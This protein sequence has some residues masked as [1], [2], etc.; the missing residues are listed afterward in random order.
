MTESADPK[1]RRLLLFDEDGYGQF[2][3]TDILPLAHVELVYVHRL[4]QVYQMI[5]EGLFDAVALN[6]ETLN[7][8]EMTPIADLHRL[9]SQLPII[10][11]SD[12]N[13]VDVALE[14]LR[15]GAVDFLVKPFNN[16]A[17]VESALANAFEKKNKALEHLALNKEIMATHG[18]LGESPVLRNMLEIIAQVAPLD[19]SVL[20]TGESGSGKELV[21]RSIHARSK[22][23]QEGFFAINCG[24][25]PDG[26]VESIFFGHKKGSFTGADAHHQGILEKADQ[27]TLFLDE[28]GEMSPK[29]QV[30]LL[31]FLQERE[32][33]RVGGVRSM[34]SDVRIIASTNRNLEEE[35]V[36]KRF[37]EDLFFRLNVVRITA[38]PLRER[39]ADILLLAEHFAR[40]F[41]LRRDQPW[42]SLSPKA[43]E[44]LLRYPW[45]GNVRELKNL[46]NGLTATLPANHQ[47]LSARDLIKFS[48]RFS[49]ASVT[50]KTEQEKLTEMGF[51][52]AQSAFARDYFENLLERHQGNVT[53]AAQAAG[54]H[55]ITLHRNLQ[56]LGLKKPQKRRSEL[57]LPAP[58]RRESAR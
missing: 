24:A 35:V 47:P 28:I 56:K 1:K 7:Y 2:F 33:V 57:N 42:S 38:P 34:T 5:Q 10:V 17:R 25:L 45:P 19:I 39:G 21:A 32:F 53:R 49:Q 52:E 26:L 51:E 6:I 58:S 31:R 3:F 23:A 48:D 43:A 4:S 27:G 37:R 50:G 13:E 29:V 54:L 11:I 20:I 8:H 15:A 46:M 18:L 22:R 44:I 36:Q 40:Q 41:C 9:D 14:S 30:T 16:L 12:R 55:P